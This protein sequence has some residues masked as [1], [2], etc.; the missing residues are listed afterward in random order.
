M[1]MGL[2]DFFGQN[3]IIPGQGNGYQPIFTC[4]VNNNNPGCGSY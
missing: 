4:P 1:A 3:R 2:P